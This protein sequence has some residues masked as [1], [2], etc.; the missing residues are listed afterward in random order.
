MAEKNRLVYLKIMGGFEA[1]GKNVK[2]QCS[3]CPRLE[4]LLDNPLQLRSLP[5]SPSLRLTLPPCL[6]LSLSLPPSSPLALPTF[7]PH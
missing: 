2:R 7:L 4:E 6:Y 5:L 3:L 1:S